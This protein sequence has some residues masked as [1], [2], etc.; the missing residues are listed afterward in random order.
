[1]AP[2]VQHRMIQV[3]RFPVCFAGQADAVKGGTRTSRS[4]Q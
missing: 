1:M 3:F 2:F 4:I